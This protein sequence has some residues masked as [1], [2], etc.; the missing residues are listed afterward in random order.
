MADLY[1]LN[2]ARQELFKKL[3]KAGDLYLKFKQEKKRDSHGAKTFIVGLESFLYYLLIDDN[4]L[5][6][7]YVVSKTKVCGAF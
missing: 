5:L 2:Y 7:E 1:K 4:V 3:K 6:A